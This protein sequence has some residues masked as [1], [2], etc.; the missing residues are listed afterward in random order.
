MKKVCLFKDRGKGISG[1][2]KG[3]D[4]NLFIGMEMEAVRAE[5]FVA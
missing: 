3:M 4:I 2:G 1:K 5:G